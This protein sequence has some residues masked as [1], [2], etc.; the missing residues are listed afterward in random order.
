M[1]PYLPLAVELLDRLPGPLC[2]RDREFRCVWFNTGFR[3]ATNACAKGS[4]GRAGRELLPPH[5]AL[6]EQ[7]RDARVF[8]T[9]HTLTVPESG[10]GG[11]GCHIA[12]RGSDGA[13][14]YVLRQWAAKDSLTSQV[15]G[16]VDHPTLERERQV[17][18]GQLAGSFAHQI[19]SPLGAIAT[20]LKMLQRQLD[21]KM[22]LKTEPLLDM[23]QE[24]IWTSNQIIAELLAYSRIRAPA[25]TNVAL[26]DLVDVV[27]A[28]DPLPEG[29]VMERRAGEHRI[30]VDAGQ[31]CDALASV[32]RHVIE[33]MDGDGTLVLATKQTAHDVALFIFT[34]ESQ[35]F[36]SR[37][38]P[39]ATQPM[40]WANRGFLLPAALMSNQQ[41]SLEWNGVADRQIGFRLRFPA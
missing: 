4:L 31:V 6:R 26:Q 15:S 14:L 12:V 1:L 25:Y 34:D 9:G 19:R 23:I 35:G 10:G 32:L 20:A 38:T 24:D 40:S 27:L 11:G 3:E 36:K 39:V 28:R 16:W 8:Q 18:L 7:E 5:Q 33:A 37:F 41:G 29:V 13:V 22:A 2:L 17:V 21:G 30:N